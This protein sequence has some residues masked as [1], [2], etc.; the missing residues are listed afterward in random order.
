MQC[1]P[2]CV[3]RHNHSGNHRK[4]LDRQ[5]HTM[6][7]VVF[8]SVFRSTLS[9]VNVKAL[10]VRD[11]TLDH[12]HQ[13]CVAISKHV[14]V[15]VYVFTADSIHTHTLF[16]IGRL[17]TTLFDTTLQTRSTTPTSPCRMTNP[18]SVPFLES[19]ARLTRKINTLTCE[20]RQPYGSRH[21]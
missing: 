12:V 19:N 15:C 5:R 17:P 9:N 13:P 1:I 16:D 10:C 20:H 8:R 4:I 21:H 2:C 6:C 18:H 14:I 7:H 11:Q 3:V